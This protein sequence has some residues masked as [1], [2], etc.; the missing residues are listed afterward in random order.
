LLEGLRPYAEPVQVVGLLVQRFGYK[1][2]EAHAVLRTLPQ[3]APKRMYGLYARRTYRLL[4]THGV[5]A[6]LRRV[7]ALD[8]IGS[9]EAL[10]RR[11]SREPT[12]DLRRSIGTAGQARERA[13]SSVP[14][15]PRLDRHN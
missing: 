8:P 10:G 11:P 2:D 9:I 15:Q 5:T 14:P 7:S 1:L 4:R 12:L 6:S 13:L 3:L